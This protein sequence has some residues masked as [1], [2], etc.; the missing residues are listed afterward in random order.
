MLS[1]LEKYK[2]IQKRKKIILL[3]A[4]VVLTLGIGS[5][6]KTTFADADVSTLLINW[7]KNKESQSLN[8][9]DKAIT[10]EKTILLAQLKVELKNEMDSA[11]QELDAFTEKQ[12][13]D[14]IASLRQYANELIENLNVDTTEQ[15]DKITAQINSIMNEAIAQ[16][17][18]AVI[19]VPETIPE[20]PPVSE[21]ENSSKPNENE[22][23]PATEPVQIPAPSTPVPEPAPISDP[24]PNP[25][26]DSTSA[27][28][29]D[30]V[31]ANRN[32]STED[33]LENSVEN[34]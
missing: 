9:I 8:E 12:K 25:E 7:F 31:Q 24:L 32:P 29:V 17:D 21:G 11:K 16:M 19:I 33:E 13:S 2:K 30:N 14:R 3:V 26:S 34:D 15:Q 5:G 6:V 22:Q 10:D 18:Q 20:V 27:N 1:R 28:G 23:E 4:V